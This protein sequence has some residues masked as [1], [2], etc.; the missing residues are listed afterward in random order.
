MPDTLN[1]NNNYRFMKKFDV[2]KPFTTRT[3]KKA[4]FLGRRNHKR[5]PLVVAIEIKEGE[6]EIYTYTEDGCH[7]VSCRETV[8]DLVNLPEKVE[9]DLWFNV[10]RRE[11][12]SLCFSHPHYSENAA[13][14]AVLEDAVAVA[15]KQHIIFEV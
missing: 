4:K 9:K 8:D 15:V 2:T 13:R 11:D 14:K 1:M 5:Y 6:D 7:L 10:Y 3:G 12:G